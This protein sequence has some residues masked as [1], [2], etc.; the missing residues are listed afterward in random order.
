MNDQLKKLYQ[1]VIIKH[2][3]DPLNFEKQ[4]DSEHDIKAYNQICGDRFNLFFNVEGDTIQNLSFHGFGCAISKASSSVL[5]EAIKGKSI[6]EAKNVVRSFLNMIDSDD[7]SEE[8][9]EDFLAFS[10]ARDF[11]GRQKCATLSWDA[12]HLF[13]DQYTDEMSMI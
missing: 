2:N 11:P 6:Q 9:S 7:Q 4:S 12:I 10:A 8:Y 3:N 5:T 1:K 13:L